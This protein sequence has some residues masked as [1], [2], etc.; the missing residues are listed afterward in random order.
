MRHALVGLSGLLLISCSG[1][2]AS[3]ALW[4]LDETRLEEELVNRQTAAQRLA[5]ARDTALQAVDESLS[6][7]AQRVGGL[8]A[9]CPG[10]PR[11]FEASVGSRRRDAARIRGDA[12]SRQRAAALAQADWFVRRA[13]ATTQATFC[14]R[15]SRALA[16]AE[17]AQPPAELVALVQALP[18]AEVQAEPAGAVGEQVDAA[19]AP[20]FATALYGIGLVDG[21]RGPAPLIAQLAGT[22]GGRLSL[23]LLAGAASVAPEEVVDRVA[24]RFPDWEPDGMYTALRAAGR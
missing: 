21:V 5:A 22:Y 13:A 1:P 9:D 16:G 3:G 7:E 15:A 4:A 11:A 17:D 14:D 12:N 6:A 24:A 23:P 20:S 10:S 8:L 2:G 18:Q 19:A